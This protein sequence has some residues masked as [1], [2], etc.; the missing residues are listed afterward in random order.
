M[1]RVAQRRH[2]VASGAVPPA[3]VLRRHRRGLVRWRRRVCK[4]GAL[5]AQDWGPSLPDVHGL[6]VGERVW[7]EKVSLTPILTLVA[8]KNL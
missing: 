3:R 6:A 5:G 8:S 7:F 2:P 4:G 1:G